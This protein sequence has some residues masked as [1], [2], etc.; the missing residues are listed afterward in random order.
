MIQCKPTFYANYMLKIQGFFQ[1]YLFPF[2]ADK[3]RFYL[4]FY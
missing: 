2:K 4:K 1:N 3:Q